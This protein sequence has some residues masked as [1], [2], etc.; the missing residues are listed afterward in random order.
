MIDSKNNKKLDLNLYSNNPTGCSVCDSISSPFHEY[1]SLYVLNFDTYELRRH[2]VKR[3]GVGEFVDKLDHDIKI[4]FGQIYAYD[5]DT[6]SDEKESFCSRECAMRW[7]KEKNSVL[8]TGGS[9]LV[10]TPHQKQLDQYARKNDLTHHVLVMREGESARI[11]ELEYRVENEIHGHERT[12]HLALRAHSWGYDSRAKEAADYILKSYPPRELLTN[13]KLLELLPRLGYYDEVNRLFEI[14]EVREGIGALGSSGYSTWGYILSY[15][16]EYHDEAIQLSK[17]AMELDPNDERSFANHIQVLKSTG[18]D[19]SEVIS[20]IEGW[21][22][23]LSQ[24]M[25]LYQVG[26][27]YLEAREYKKAVRP[28]KEAHLICSDSATKRDLAEA[29]WKSGDPHEALAVCRSGRKETEGG[30]RQTYQDLDGEKVSVAEKERESKMYYRKI[31]LAM[32]GRLLID[33]GE[34]DSG[35]KLIKRSIDINLSVDDRITNGIEKLV[36]NYD[37]KKEL[38]EKVQNKDKEIENL[39]E[40]VSELREK[41]SSSEDVESVRE[42]EKTIVSVSEAEAP[43]IPDLRNDAER[44]ITEYHPEASD[45]ATESLREAYYLRYVLDQ[46]GTATGDWAAPMVHLVKALERHLQESLN[47]IGIQTQD[48]CTLGSLLRTLNHKLQ[49]ILSKSSVTEERLFRYVDTIK[50]IKDDFRNSYVHE[51]SMSRSK[52]NELFR[53]GEQRNI[54]FDIKAE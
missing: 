54:F 11:K 17:T 43:S 24:H 31:F 3:I 7:A 36:K 44:S 38:L 9:T 47:S 42:I 26:S 29:L 50:E 13:M 2:E 39:K 16:P 22:G 20:F 8:L 51:D 27:A 18:K 52:I 28:L 48:E 46:A 21:G 19:L 4:V 1:R 25:S 15:S 45:S 10:V 32:E 40:K 23:R 6:E 37:S 41:A 14:F 5:V 49:E 34:E 33:V 53:I 35:K 12:A 30:D